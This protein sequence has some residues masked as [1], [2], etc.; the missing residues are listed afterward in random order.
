LITDQ[1]QHYIM[2]LE[3][4][5]LNNFLFMQLFFYRVPQWKLRHTPLRYVVS[6]CHMFKGVSVS[7]FLIDMPR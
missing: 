7:F 3:Q 2:L 4:F 6:S 5:T 1:P